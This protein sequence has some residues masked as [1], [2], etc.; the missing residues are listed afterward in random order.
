MNKLIKF[1][2]NLRASFWFLPSLMVTGSIISAVV[3]IEADSDVFDRWLSQW[4]RLFGV[5]AEGAR[6]M[7]ATLAGSMMTV[8][9]ITFSMTLLALVLASGQYTSRI[10]RNFMRSR[11]TQATLGVFAGIFAYCL[12]VLR[13]IRGGGGEY[14]FVPGLAVFF[15]FI[16]S[17]GG[18]G[19]LIYF[20][21]HIALSIQAASIIA[22]V[23][24]ETNTAI[25]RLLPEKLDQVPE[26]DEGWNQGLV[27]LDDRDWY[28]V[29]AAVSG[30][31]QSV[32]DDALLHLAE[33]N[34]TI[35]RM[36]HG[37]GAFVVQDTALG[38]L[39]LTYAP[40]QKTI[41]AFN[42]AYSIGRHRTVEE[43]PAFGI[44]QI[45]DMA[46]KALS[47]GVN[48]TSTAVMCVDYLSSILARLAVRQFPPSHRY[49]GETLRV[50]AIVPS[51]EDLLADAFDQIRG[52]AEV[53]VAVLTRMLGALETIGSLTIRPGHFRALDEQL[54][55]IAE[56]ADRCIKSSYDRAH[57]ERRLAEVRETLEAQ[58]ASCGREVKA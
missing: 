5:G 4:P 45:V 56:L 54:Q 21:H 46:I 32:N 15:A 35:V 12:I 51:F 57:L 50:I 47:P 20:I 13:T 43:D 55:C 28:P 19:I 41:D 23:A 16:M 49:E 36:E 48:D 52:N 33:D 10:L 37:I 25:D 58:S 34:R 3:L 14:E 38:S 31:V 26:E 42:A 17:L 18:I 30:Y 24:D 22:S 39:A 53:N 44:R 29:L 27:S 2:G 11:V 6:Q 9:G 7:L 40:E 1:W 8:M